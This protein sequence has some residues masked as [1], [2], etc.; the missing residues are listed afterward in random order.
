MKKIILI[1]HGNFALELKRS[2]EMIMGVQ[3]N[4]ATAEL[5]PEEG[6]KDFKEKFEGLL[7]I[8]E[9]TTVFA[10]LMGGTPCNIAATVLMEKNFHYKLYSGMNMPMLLNY[11]NEEDLEIDSNPIQGAIQGIQCINDILGDL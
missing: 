8:N 6:P 2:I 7:S 3:D 11:I 5:L 9:E 10:D 1:S 4:I